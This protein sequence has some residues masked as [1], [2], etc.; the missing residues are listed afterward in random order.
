MFQ[1]CAG[2]LM[3]GSR[4]IHRNQI[5]FLSSDNFDELLKYNY[6]YNFGRQPESHFLK[7]WWSPMVRSKNSH[8][9]LDA[10]V[11]GFIYNCIRSSTMFRTEGAIG[12]SG[13]SGKRPSNSG[14][15]LDFHLYSIRL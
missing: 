4:T 6:G 7:N 5:Y 2:K 11:R 12:I 10:I 13:K 1:T 9:N 8:F 15:P 14:I 3:A